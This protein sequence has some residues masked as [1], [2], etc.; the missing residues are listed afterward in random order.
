MGKI[1]TLELQQ[2]K[3]KDGN[4]DWEKMEFGKFTANF[5]LTRSSKNM[6]SP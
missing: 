5:V 2:K 6:K 4:K 1:T 3:L